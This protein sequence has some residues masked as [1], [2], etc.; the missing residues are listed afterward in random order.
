MLAWTLSLLMTVVGAAQAD[1]WECEECCKDAGMAGC[2]TR[3]RVFGDGSLAVKEGTIWRIKGLWFVDCD[4]GVTFDEGATVVVAEP[5]RSGEV[6]RLASPAQ[7]VRCFEQSCAAQLPADACIVEHENELFRLVNCSSQEALTQGQMRT[8]SMV[9]RTPRQPQ[10]TQTTQ[11]IEPLPPLEQTLTA[12]LS[13]PQPPP[14]QCN[15]SEVVSEEA[16]RRLVLGDA[17]RVSGDLHEAVQ[18]YLAAVAMDRCSVNGWSALGMAAL[19]GGLLN[20][21]ETALEI[22][23]NL[24]DGHY[25]AWTALGEVRERQGMP[26]RALSAYEAA[27]TVQPQHPPAMR[28]VARIQ[29]GGTP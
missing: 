21:A 8:T 25:G 12:P 7:T 4:Q 17:A 6:L 22:A 27:L 1:G 10:L 18:E 28:A 9:A 26:Q 23:V 29:A 15:T 24:D 11:P 19:S 3:I 14:Q 5:P 2:P 20:D 13:M 16:D